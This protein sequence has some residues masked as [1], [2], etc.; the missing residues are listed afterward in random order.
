[1]TKKSDLSLEMGFQKSFVISIIIKDM[2]I[3]LVMELLNFHHELFTNV[4]I[5]LC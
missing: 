5:L 3:K 2:F 4:L 1:M